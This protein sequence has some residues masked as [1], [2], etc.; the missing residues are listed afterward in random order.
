M[1]PMGFKNNTVFFLFSARKLGKTS[2]LTSTAYFSDGLVHPPTRNAAKNVRREQSAAAGYTSVKGSMAIA[3]AATPKFGGDL[4][5]G[6]M[7]Y[8][9]VAS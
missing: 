9:G 2:N 1:D 4:F 8:M 3:T 7:I 5:F 6:A